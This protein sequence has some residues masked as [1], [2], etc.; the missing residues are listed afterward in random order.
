MNPALLNYMQQ[1]GSQMQPEQGQQMAQPQMQGNAPYNPFDGGVQKAIESARE[2]LGMTEKQQDKALRK[3][4]LTFADRVGQEPVKKGFWGN[5]GSIARSLG[6]AIGAYD[7]AD[8]AAINENNNLANQILGYKAQEQARQAQAEER[9]WH[10]KHAEAQL[11]ETRR[12]HNLLDNFNKEKIQAEKLAET[13]KLQGKAWESQAKN[14][15]T[16]V[17]PELTTNYE[18]NQ[19]M[20]PKID[21]L[22]NILSNSKLA[23][24]SKAAELRRYVAKI[25]GTDEDILKAKNAG[26]FY[27]EWLKQNTSGVLSDK[28]ITVYSAGFA[29]I[30]KN[31]QAGIEAL[32]NLKNQV[33]SYQN[34]IKQRL[35]LFDSDPGTNLSKLGL[36][37]RD[38]RSQQVN[39]QQ[40]I[41]NTPVNEEYIKIK[42]PSG[43]IADVYI[44]DA[45]K[46]L[47]KPGYEKVQ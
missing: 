19:E 9:A 25:T 16:K 26:Q 39:P 38:V 28:D 3:S 13:Q 2:S 6:P 11:G 30:E 24:S 22:S 35:E 5:F 45:N 15:I 27:L 42:G 40:V 8:T 47:S 4:M 23:G 7:E 17:V 33:E 29:D 12:Y 21:N 31:P 32:K 10:R 34:T 44:E 41:N 14:N 1:Q 18:K 46:L 43:Q 20:L 37:H 36:I